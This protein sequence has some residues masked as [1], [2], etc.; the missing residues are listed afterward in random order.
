[1]E[2]EKWNSIVDQSLK[3]M[4]EAMQQKGGNPDEDIFYFHPNEDRI[5]LSHALFWVLSKPLE[6]S[7]SVNKCFLLLRHFEEDMLNAYL[8]E[9]DDYADLLQSCNTLYQALLYVLRAYAKTP[10]TKKLSEKLGAMTI[11]AGGFGGDMDDD[12]ADELLDDMDF[13]YNKVRCRKIEQ[14]LPMLNH[15]V[16]EELREWGGL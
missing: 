16:E 9:S 15:M 10:K 4:E 3:Y 11:V 8:T 5:V 7:L 2:K 6:K 14:M 1:M 12:L 13:A